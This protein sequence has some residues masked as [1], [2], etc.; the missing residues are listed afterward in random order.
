MISLDALNAWRVHHPWSDDDQVEQDLIMTRVAIEIALHPELRDRLAW[1]G[2]TCLHK[3]FLPEALRYSED[4]D[5]VAY[6]LSIEDNDMRR[7]R[8]GLRDVAHNIE[9]EVSKNAKTTRGRLTEHLA[10]T[11]RG[12]TTHRIKVEIKMDE[13]PAFAPLERRALSAETDWWTGGADLLTF[14]PVELI[15]T[16]FRALAQRSKGRDLNDLDIA[17]RTLALHDELLGR[18]AA[19]YLMHAD[20]SPGEFRARLVA[21][22]ADP[23]FVVDVDAYL[24]DPAFAGDPTTLVERWVTWTERYLDLPFAKAAL[25]LAL[26]KRKERAVE[27]IELRLGLNADKPD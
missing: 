2:G 15:A 21:H 26:S 18:A 22:L 19:H 7:L 27:E 8:A 9:L 10:Y 5:Y 23:D 1:R 13:V 6:D 16:K 24:L 17:H 3:V 4:L 25:T 20:V 11:S 14:D 12:G